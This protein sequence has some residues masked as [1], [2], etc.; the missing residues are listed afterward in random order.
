MSRSG[1]GRGKSKKPFSSESISDR[2]ES[3]LG[4]EDNKPDAKNFADVGSPI[5]TLHGSGAATFATTSSSSSS[6]SFSGKPPPN[7]ASSTSKSDGGARK[8]HSGELSGSSDG[9]PK[10]KAGHRRSGSGQMMFSGAVGASTGVS[11]SASSPTT[12]LLPAGN[13]CPSG[14]I[15]K[16]GMMSRSSTRSDVLGSGSGN[17]GHGSIMRGTASGSAKLS[18]F[19]ETAMLGNLMARKTDPEE[20][21]KAGNDHYKKGHFAEALSFYDRAMEMCPGNAACR[22]NRAAALT[23]LERLEEAVKECEEAIRLDPSYA[24]AHHRLSCIFLRLGH[25]ENARRHLFLAGQQVELAEM[26]QI[27]TVERHLARCADARRVRDW[28]SALREADAAISAGVDSSPLISAFR[29]EALLRLHHLEEAN[30]TLAKAF[31]YGVKSLSCFP[32][33]FLGMLSGSYICFVQAQVEM[34]LGRFENAVASAEKAKQIDPRNG[35]VAVMWN[36]VKSVSRARTQGNELFKS[37]NF[38]EASTAYGEGLKYDPSNPVLLCNRAACRSKLGQWERSLEDCNEALRIQPTYTKAL[39][40]RAASYSKIERWVEAVRDYE[41]LRKEF[42][43]DTEVAEALFH[44]QVALKM[45]RGEEVS[46]MKFGGEVEQITCLEQLQ[47]AISLTGVSVVCFIAKA[48]QQCIQTAQ[49][50]DSFCA[51]YPS[52]NFLKVD[53][54]ASPEVATAED[55]RIVPTIKIYKN[56]AKMK[57]MICPSKQVLDLALK[58]YGM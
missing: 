44:A 57:E 43:A 49:L 40:R 27:Q 45:S 16:I 2:F 17:Y 11:S 52:L 25:V 29:A 19:G 24:K 34:A 28:K 42:P 46:N 33:K 39:L 48:N 53:I 22:N 10:P 51:R 26:Q 21:T 35:E 36:N 58:H 23:G 3:T 20:V 7:A 8:S 31:K 13:I 56:G 38:A 50:V 4:F 32:L 55:V 1:D 15:G 6:G 30:S 54:N 14:K 41:V 9:S 37:G 5:S 47:A 18:G 12:N